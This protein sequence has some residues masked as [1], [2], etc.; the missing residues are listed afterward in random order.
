MPITNPNDMSTPNSVDL[1][2]LKER[3]NRILSSIDSLLSKANLIP[4]EDG[5]YADD[6]IPTNIGVDPSNT[7]YAGQ[8]TVNLHE[9]LDNP[10]TPTVP[11]PEELANLKSDVEMA[12]ARAN[13]S[14]SKTNT[15]DAEINQVRAEFGQVKSIA[16]RALS[17][18]E[19]LGSS[20]SAV[21]ES[22]A[23][24]PDYVKGQ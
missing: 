19:S 17:K 6:F 15:L 1:S 18:A 10:E 22:N 3:A 7:I 9:P 24:T 16:L 5:V 23:E 11:Q 14:L 13:E 4:D 20:G 12:K 21:A 2:P 8:Q